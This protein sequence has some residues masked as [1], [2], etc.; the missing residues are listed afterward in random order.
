M[1]WKRYGLVYVSA[2]CAVAGSLWYLRAVPDY[3]AIDIADL[4]CGLLERQ[5]ASLRGAE[6]WTN[7]LTLGW[8]DATTSTPP[9][10]LA[11][12]HV[13]SVSNAYARTFRPIADIYAGSALQPLAWL[14]AAPTNGQTLYTSTNIWTASASDSNA[15]TI[16]DGAR[17]GALAATCD[18][19][20]CSGV[21]DALA[22]LP[23]SETPGLP[24]SR[25]SSEV[26]SNGVARAGLPLELYDGAG[27]LSGLTRR[28]GSNDLNVCRAALANMTRA[29][30]IA[31]YADSLH[32]YG[33]VSITNHYTRMATSGSTNVML[34]TSSELIALAGNGQG[35]STN[36]SHSVYGTSILIARDYFSSYADSTGSSSYVQRERL[37]SL[38][39]ALGWPC[40]QLCASGMVRRVRIYGVISCAY[41]PFLL[42][43][44]TT[45][46]AN[47]PL[48]AELWRTQFPA[49]FWPVS[50]FPLYRDAHGAELLSFAAP[51]AGSARLPPFSACRAAL[52]ATIDSPAYPL[53]A[54]IEIPAAI[55]VPQSWTYSSNGAASAW[56]GTYELA[57]EELF[58][59]AEFNFNYQTNGV[60]Q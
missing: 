56:G 42:S 27:G 55:P 17:F 11:V 41:A 21:A 7:A 18:A 37:L 35:L 24:I 28:I 15:W 16:C 33:V 45:C 49:G 5:A 51:D 60:P 44:A 43:D 48:L 4:R 52:L 36:E 2:A 22:A 9:A 29:M 53:S 20:D 13:P 32:K 6:T 23:A 59:V 14:A 46:N 8:G 10:E 1:N 30:H 47:T 3:R 39:I 50:D 12:G 26:W 31:P 19:P 40:E 25:W 34:S 54:A 38:D 58:A 57:L